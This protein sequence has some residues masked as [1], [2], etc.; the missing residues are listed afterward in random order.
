MTIFKKLCQPVNFP[1]LARQCDDGAENEEEFGLHHML[2]M[3]MTMTIDNGDDDDDDY[4]DND[5]D[6]DDYDKPV[7]EER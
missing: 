7:R 6:D 4:D 5:V 2:T 3:M 1:S